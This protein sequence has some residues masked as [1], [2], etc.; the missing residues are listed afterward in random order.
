MSGCAYKTMYPNLKL[1]L[2]KINLHNE[3]NSLSPAFLNFSKTFEKNYS[4]YYNK[5]VE[6]FDDSD[7]S[8][9]NSSV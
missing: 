3:N 5:K 1:K 7:D 4:E 9:S 8:L 6:F 2:G